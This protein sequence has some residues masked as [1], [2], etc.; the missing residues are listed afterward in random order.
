MSR[1]TPLLVLLVLAA[2]AVAV[3]LWL[4]GERR[5]GPV[6]QVAEVRRG[7]AIEGVYA[8]G[9]V[10]PVFWARLSPV[11][12]ARIEAVEV[13]EGEA[14][15]RGQVLVRLEGREVEARVRELEARVRYLQSDAVRRSELA[16]RGAMSSQIEEQALSELTQAEAALAAAAETREHYIL[17]AP[18]DG[19]VLRRDGEPGEIARPGDV[20]VQVGRL[21][22]LRIVA[23]VDE[24]DIPLVARDQR[25]L[26]RADA[27]PGRALEGSVAEITPRGDPTRK[28]YRVRIA[29]PEDTPL[30][31][32]MTV[33]TNIIVRQEEAA[34]LV[35]EAALVAGRLFVVEDGVARARPVTIG[36]LGNDAAEIRSG[37]RLG[38]Q[39]IVAPPAGLAD[40]DVVRTTPAS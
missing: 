29:L 22:P 33:E 12:T 14:V 3:A 13:H 35:P 6:V 11:E 21:R 28:T 31:I 36:V 4:L 40:G 10:E 20:L 34:L 1:R 39:V 9:N 24:E 15:M 8:S 27:F 23:E 2:G 25:A 5:A 30:L 16:R 17:R 38:E 26:I 18:M 19:T 37:V 32:G 7:P